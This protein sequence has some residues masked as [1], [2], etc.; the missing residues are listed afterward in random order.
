M[1]APPH[2]PD[3]LFLYKIDSYTF[4]KRRF[5][6]NTLKRRQNVH[7]LKVEIPLRYIYFKIVVPVVHWDL[8]NL[9]NYTLSLSTIH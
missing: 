5:L 4:V 8:M 6:I 3:A 1:A 7:L 2:P 9:Q